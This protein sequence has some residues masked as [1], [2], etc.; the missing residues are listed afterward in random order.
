ML[1]IDPA[2]LSIALGTVLPIL[3]GIITKQFRSGAVKSS[4]L[5]LLSA[6]SGAATVAINDGGVL[7]KETIIAA[8]ITWVT[9]VAT[10][11]G[12]L[13]PSGV[14]PKVNEKTSN[15]GV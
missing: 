7:T 4:L 13:K 11:V 2:V 3:V 1:E 8:A 14:S 12:F 5:A 9:A 6:V 15:F 10:Y